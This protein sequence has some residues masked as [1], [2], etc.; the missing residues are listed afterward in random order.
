[1]KKTGIIIII[2]LFITSGALAVLYQ[3]SISHI[4]TPPQNE[5]EIVVPPTLPAIEQTE[6]LEVSF[7]LDSKG[8]EENILLT[9]A[10]NVRDYCSS[11]S[12]GSLHFVFED[13]GELEGGKVHAW[14]ELLFIWNNGQEQAVHISIKKEE[15]LP[16]FLFLQAGFTSET[17]QFDE[18]GIS[19]QCFRLEPGTRMPLGCGIDLTHNMAPQGGVHWK[20][21][22]IVE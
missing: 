16:P 1:M 15:S 7:I 9:P 13:L 8:N 20:F 6:G 17:L 22:I 21:T 18:R 19:V 11:D 3:R 2:L 10:Q 5:G 14:P 12:N 4:V